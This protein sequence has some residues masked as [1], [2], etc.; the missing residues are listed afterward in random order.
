MVVYDRVKKNKT[1]LTY[2]LSAIWHGFYPGYYL[3]FANGA[4]IT[5]ASRSVSCVDLETLLNNVHTCMNLLVVNL[6]HF[7]PIDSQTH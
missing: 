7:F 2:A 4:L 6:F 3:T 5:F 1:N